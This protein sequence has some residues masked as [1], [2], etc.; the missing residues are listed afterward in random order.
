MAHMHP[1]MIRVFIRWGLLEPAVEEPEQLF[2][3]T[4]VPRIWKIIRLRRDLGINLAGIGLV[5]DLLDRIEELERELAWVR[6]RL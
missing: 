3:D 1:D 2:P 5:L 4:L 6:N